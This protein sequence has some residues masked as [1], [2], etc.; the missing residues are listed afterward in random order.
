MPQL[1]VKGWGL[2]VCVEGKNIMDPSN[3]LAG[4]WEQA[5]GKLEIK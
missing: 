4:Q 5:R 1:Q 2:T 3:A